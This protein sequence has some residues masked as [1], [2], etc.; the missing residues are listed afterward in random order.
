ML[1]HHHLRPVILREAG[2]VRGAVSAPPVA[3]ATR[4]INGDVRG[5]VGAPPVAPATRRIDGDVPV[6]PETQRIDGGVLGLLPPMAD[7][8]PVADPPEDPDDRRPD[9]DAFLA[10]P[11]VRFTG[12]GGEGRLTTTMTVELHLSVA[13]LLSSPDR[14]RRA[15]TVQHCHH[16]SRR[17]I[18][19]RRTLAQS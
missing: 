14:L 3:P 1:V 5:A 12:G 13:A 9:G 19:L 18:Y 6:A 17:R 16:P 15:L 4:R 7:G 11:L 8:T 10:A 2:D